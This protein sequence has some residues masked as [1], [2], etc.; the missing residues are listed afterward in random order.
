MRNRI[1]KFVDSNTFVAS[2]RSAGFTLLEFIIVAGVLIM[3]LAGMVF[4]VRNQI[5]GNLE[6]DA[7]IIAARLGETQARALAGVDGAAWGMHFEN[8]LSSPPFYSLFAGSSYP[9]A[10]SS[11]Y[12]LSSSVEFQTP[13][14]GGSTNIV[15]NKLSGTIASTATVV[16]RSKTDPLRTKTIAVTAEGKISVE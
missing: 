3:L 12:F 11:T 8:P 2:N 14:P 15:F 4:V 16:I 1:T 5:L 13:A 6:S 10:A 7:A 9:S